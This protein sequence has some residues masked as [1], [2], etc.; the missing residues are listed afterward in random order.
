[1][2]GTHTLG[3][4]AGMGGGLFTNWGRLDREIEGTFDSLDSKSDE[5][6][7]FLRDPVLKFKGESGEL[8]GAV[9]THPPSRD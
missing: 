5:L 9:R 4:L 1:M 8:R 3:P 7:A 2:E 6:T